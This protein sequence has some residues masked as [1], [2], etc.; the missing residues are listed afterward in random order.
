MEPLTYTVLGD[1]IALAR[2]RM[3]G[4]NRIIYDSQKLIKHSILNQLI[5]QHGT[6]P[7]YKGPC[8]LDVIFYIRAPKVSLVKLQSLIGKPYPFKSDL[9]NLI[10]MVC[11]VAQ[12]GDEKEDPGLLLQDDCI[13]TSI[14]AKKVY[15]IIPRTVFTITEI[16]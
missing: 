14:T 2:P 9:D 1:P 13:V 8:H 3:S 12:M 15:D 6:R 5:E 16:K 10:K 4:P 11:D 7:Q